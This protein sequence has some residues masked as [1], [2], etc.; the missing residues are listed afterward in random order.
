MNQVATYIIS[1]TALCQ[2]KNELLAI[3]N[4]KVKVPAHFI[5]VIDS[6]SDFHGGKTALLCL[7]RLEF[8]AKCPSMSLGKPRAARR[9]QE[10][11]ILKHAML[12]SDHS[13]GH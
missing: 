8:A 4:P 5:P 11:P 1:K 6:H 13:P 2:V 7:L 3:H 10:I 9:A 12:C